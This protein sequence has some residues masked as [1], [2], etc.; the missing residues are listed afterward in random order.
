MAQFPS[1]IPSDAPITPG[2]WPATPHASLNGE[3]SRV[4]HGS[5][6]IGRSWRPSFVNVTEADF[7]AILSHYRGQNSGMDSFAF[8]T[9]TLAAD[10]T[11][12][13]FAWIYASPP[14]ITDYHVDC[15]TVACDFTCE[16]RGMA[17]APGVAWR[18]GATTF[19]PGARSGGIVYAAGAAWVTTETTFTLG[20]RNSG[21]GS[22]GVKWATSSTTFMPGE[23]NSGIGSNGVKWAT[24]LTTFT[25]GLRRVGPYLVAWWDASDSANRTTVSG[26]VS[27]LVDK[28]G[29]GWNLSQS[30]DSLRPALVASA[31]NGLDAMEWPSTAGDGFG[32]GGNAK[33]LFTSR[34]DTFVAGEVYAVVKYTGANLDG[35]PGLIGPNNNDQNQWIIGSSTSNSFSGV[36]F[37]QFFLNG[38]SSNQNGNILPTMASSCLIR[39]RLSSGGTESTTSG[40]A[41]GMDRDYGFL[42]RGWRGFICEVLVYS[43][44]LSSGDRAT[45][46]SNLRNKWA[47]PIVA[48]GVVWAAISTTFTPGDRSA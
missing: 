28:S 7:L 33:R 18:T 27:E 8:G 21:V 35:F 48:D 12:T 3:E 22:D 11:P 46:I 36:T 20:V 29:G 14:Q 23:R 26:N 47:T 19:A 41:L 13:G 42:G 31:I 45:V 43:D 32:S 16:P 6:E 40:V 10:L 5:A 44:P 38:G 37:N 24:D 30:S 2:A 34:S 15:F 9:A 25:P 4:R 1:L 17:L 39:A